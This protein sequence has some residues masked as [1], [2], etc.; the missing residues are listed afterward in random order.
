MVENIV[1]EFTNQ[2]KLNKKDFLNYV[3]R[4]VFRTIRKYSMLPENRKIVLKT[5]DDLNTIVL[6]HILET[7][8][9]VSFSTKS[10]FSSDNLS[11]ISEKSFN[12]ILNGKF[13]EPKNSSKLKMPLSDI[14]DKEIKVYASLVGLKGKKKKRD[15]RIQELF[16]RF[17]KKNPD[18][19][20]NIVNA[21][22]QLQGE[23]NKDF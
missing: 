15:K 11:D 19:E 17:M 8:F 3:E 12:N 20:H 2:R 14:S 18:L 21:V 22:E 4:K 16:E 6:K 5:S 10:S 13:E 7:K 23:K 1:W 9:P